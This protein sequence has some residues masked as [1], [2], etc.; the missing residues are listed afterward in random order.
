MSDAVISLCILLHCYHSK[1]SK[2]PRNMTIWHMTIILLDRWVFLAQEAG[3]KDKT[4]NI[5]L[6][7]LFASTLD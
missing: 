4:Q 1:D 5:Y 6:G 7:W 2:R 3:A